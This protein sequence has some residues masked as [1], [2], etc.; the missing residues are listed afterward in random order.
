MIA[1]HPWD[2]NKHSVFWGYQHCLSKYEHPDDY[3]RALLIVQVHLSAIAWDWI[4]FVV[5]FERVHYVI[6]MLVLNQRPLWGH[7][8]RKKSCIR[9]HL[10]MEKFSPSSIV[11]CFRHLVAKNVA[12]A[13]PYV[14]ILS[15][16]ILMGDELSARHKILWWMQDVSAPVHLFQIRCHGKRIS[17]ESSDDWKQVLLHNQTHL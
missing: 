6:S 5:L 1:H 9:A 11:S 8:L 3:P 16:N 17:P 13:M 15:S 2:S 10:V 14:K 4:L 12:D 7:H